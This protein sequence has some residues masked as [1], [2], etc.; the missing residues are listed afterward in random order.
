MNTFEGFEVDKAKQFVAVNPDG[1]LIGDAILFHLEEELFDLVGHP[2]VID[3]VLFHLQR[4]EHDVTAE[5]DDN[6]AVRTDGPP[7]FYRYELQG[8]TAAAVLE[9]ATGEP[10]PA[11]KFFH[12]ATFTIAGTTVRGLRHGMAGQPGFELFGPW[13]EGEKVLQALL[14]AGADHGLVRPGRRPTP[15]PTWSRAGCPPR[16]PQ[17]S[18]STRCCRSTGSGCRPARSA[19]SGQR[20]LRRDQRL[21][22]DPLRHRL[23]P[24]RE[25]RPRLRRPEALEALAADPPRRKVTLVWEPRTSPPRWHR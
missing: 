3:W 21:L 17:C 2:M 1:Q 15:P 16:S 11:T 10:L 6:S 20:R 23:R 7:R 4:G 19:P 8:P 14:E 13:A 22:P 5:R 25:V 24:E 9:Q 18:A 12:M